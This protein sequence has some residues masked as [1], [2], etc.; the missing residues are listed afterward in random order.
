MT[1]PLQKMRLVLIDMYSSGK[2]G[3]AS[4][5]AENGREK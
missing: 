2:Y 3:L 5:L 4:I 1:S